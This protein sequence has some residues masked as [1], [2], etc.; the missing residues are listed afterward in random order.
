MN[1]IGRF[2]PVAALAA[3]AVSS[4]GAGPMSGPGGP[5]P[6]LATRG[7]AAVPSAQTPARAPA[8][9]APA[10]PTAPWAARFPPPR[11]GPVAPWE[12]RVTHWT[13]DRHGHVNG[14]HVVV[15]AVEDNPFAGMP[16]VATPVAGRPPPPPPPAERIVTE[17][18][19]TERVYPLPEPSDAAAERAE[20]KAL[21]EK[22]GDGAPAVRTVDEARFR[23]D[24][25][26]IV[27]NEYRLDGR[28]LV[29][30]YEYAV[31]GASVRKTAR[32]EAAPLPQPGTEAVMAAFEAGAVFVVPR[33][34]SFAV[35]CG[36]CAGT[37]RVAVERIVRD[38]GSPARI[39]YAG[40]RRCNGGGSKKAEATRLFEVSRE[41]P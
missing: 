5:G 6:F 31:S 11:V 32:P 13:T 7:P 19:V 40:C 12:P 38:D 16:L 35:P 28:T 37:G 26:P 10:R 39:G 24:V 3:L 4:Q 33:K 29:P 25:L 22:L 8:P 36:A 1:G 41:A 34:A 27:R 14:Y 18:V 15:P 9:V 30:A 20:R 2:F 17:R 21:L 23:A